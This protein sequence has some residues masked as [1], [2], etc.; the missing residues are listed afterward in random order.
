LLEIINIA[1]KKRREGGCV[2]HVEEKMLEENG[3]NFSEMDMAEEMDE[4]YSPGNKY[5][6]LHDEDKIRKAIKILPKDKQYQLY[7]E[8]TGEWDKFDLAT[9]IGNLATLGERLY[10]DNLENIV[11][12]LEKHTDFERSSWRILKEYVEKTAGETK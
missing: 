3:I 7:A 10:I 8:I 9:L 6:I 5:S 1:V 4:H 2:D 11:E 12:W